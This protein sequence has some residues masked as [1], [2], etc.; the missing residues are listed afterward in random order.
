MKEHEEAAA[1]LIRILNTLAAGMSKR[2]KIE[3]EAEIRRACELLSTDGTLAPLD[4]LPRAVESEYI[5]ASA[6][7][8]QAWLD[9]KREREG[10]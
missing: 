1:I 3:H 10:R 4:D 8:P 9:R 6:A 5:P 2:L 7:I